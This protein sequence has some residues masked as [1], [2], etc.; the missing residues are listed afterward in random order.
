MRGDIRS[1]MSTVHRQGFVHCASAD[2]HGGNEIPHEKRQTTIK[3]ATHTHNMSA[4]RRYVISATYLL[5]Y[6]KINSG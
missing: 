6:S 4:S 2:V 1:Q 3:Y 5:L